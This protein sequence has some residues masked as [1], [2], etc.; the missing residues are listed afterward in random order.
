[1]RILTKG[2]KVLKRRKEVDYIRRDCKHYDP[3]TME[4]ATMCSKKMTGI[5]DMLCK[6]CSYY[7]MSK[8][9]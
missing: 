4:Y 1:M 6:G 7:R 3:Y 2:K 9:A 5:T 8:D